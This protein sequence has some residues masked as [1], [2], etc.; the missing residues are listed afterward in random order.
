MTDPEQVQ[1]TQADAWMFKCHVCGNDTRHTA[2]ADELALLREALD[3]VQRHSNRWDGANGN[4][5]AGIADRLTA[6]IAKIE[7]D[8]K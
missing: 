8:T 7:G 5:P 3:F 6:A 2:T 4:H 1:V